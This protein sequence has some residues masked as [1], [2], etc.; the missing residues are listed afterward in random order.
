MIMKI[1]S[2]C[3]FVLRNNHIYRAGT[4]VVAKPLN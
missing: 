2:A 4:A 1:R 3:V